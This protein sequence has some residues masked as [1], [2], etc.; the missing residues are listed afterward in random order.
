M[1][2][3]THPG[4]GIDPAHPAVDLSSLSDEQVEGF[5]DEL[6]ESEDD[7]GRPPRPR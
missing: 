3:T 4:A 7:V 1:T 6:T 5:L 2:T